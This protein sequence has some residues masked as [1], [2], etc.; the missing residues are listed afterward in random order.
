MYSEVSSLKSTKFQVFVQCSD[1]EGHEIFR[2]IGDILLNDDQNGFCLKTDDVNEAIEE[3]LKVESIY[4][5][6][7]KSL[8]SVKIIKVVIQDSRMR[9]APVLKRIEVWGVPSF[10][11]TREEN[12]NINRLIKGCEK[13]LEL[14]REQ[15]TDSPAAG[16]SFN[17]PEDYLDSITNDLLVMP[18]ILPSGNIIDETTMEKHNRH[19]ESYGRLPSDPFTGLIYTADHQPKFNDVL[20]VRLDQFKLK[21]SHEIDVKNSGRILGKKVELVASTSSS[22]SSYSTSGHVSKKIKLN[23]SS[24]S[25]LESLISSIYKNNQVSIFTKP[26]EMKTVDGRCVCSKCQTASFS[27]CYKILSCSHLFCK[28]CLLDLAS[29]CVTCKTS[30][31]SKDVVK[32]NH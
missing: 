19:E 12:M 21:N 14:F 29:I 31:Q 25:D 16:P 4:P 5:Y 20:K 1:F 2:K 3:S 23:G 15:K 17:I 8:R 9:R 26:K 24:S 18:F 6:T 7:R 32:F 11:N 27:G 22:T 13:P 28:P 10:K 30:F